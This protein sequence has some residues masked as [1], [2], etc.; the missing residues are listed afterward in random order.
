M[1]IRD[2]GSIVLTA[3]R[4]SDEDVRTR[5]FIPNPQYLKNTAVVHDIIVRHLLVAVSN[6]CVLLRRDTLHNS[7]KYRLSIQRQEEAH[8]REQSRLEME[9][10]K[11]CV[12]AVKIQSVFKGHVA[13]EQYP[14]TH[15]QDGDGGTTTTSDSR[16]LQQIELDNLQDWAAT[17]MQSMFRMWKARYVV[18]TIRRDHVD[19]HRRRIQCIAA[20]FIQRW[21]LRWRRRQC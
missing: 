1:C 9:E 2:S 3:I 12:A 6:Q 5:P 18:A 13:R 11:K 15:Q 16:Y 20:K 7:L 4:T 10:T 8:Q 17:K 14:I 19:R 21:W